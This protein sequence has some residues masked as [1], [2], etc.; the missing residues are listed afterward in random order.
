[1]MPFPFLAD[2]LAAGWLRAQGGQA[3]SCS[4]FQVVVHGALAGCFGVG[5]FEADYSESDGSGLD[6]WLQQ[7]YS[8]VKAVG[9]FL[10][11][12]EEL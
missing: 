4:D 3:L 10:V 1:M 5:C 6:C 9:C 11:A 12:R 2:C 8:L 7:P